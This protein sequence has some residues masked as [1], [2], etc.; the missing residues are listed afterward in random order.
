MDDET[1]SFARRG[2]EVARG[3]V[4]PA[5]VEAMRSLALAHLAADQGPLERE[6]EVGYPGAPSSVDAEGGGTVRRLLSAYARGAP[7]RGFV[8]DPRLRKKLES[9]LGDTPVAFSPNHHNCIMTKQ[10]RYSSDTGWHRDVRYWHFER[11]HLVNAWLALTEESSPNGS[12]RFLP[13][14]H[15]LDLP[16]ERFDEAQFLRPEHR[17]NRA[18][19][20]QAQSVELAPGDVLFFHARLFHF[21]TRNFTD[22][23]KL[24]AVF[25]FF[26]G[27]NR[28]L[29]HTKSA[30]SPAI[31]L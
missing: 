7:F 31:P 26:G 24:S 21:A 4:D 14:T 15:R 9:Y 1:E 16:D 23:P 6:A 10:P 30:R 28:P 11:P 13:G 27:R 20:E 19:I 22:T 25:T 29:P 17:D 12:L 18:L 8:H 2:Y 3:F 5:H